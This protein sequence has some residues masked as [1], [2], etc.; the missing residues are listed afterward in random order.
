MNGVKD[1]T[2]TKNT[3]KTSFK[4]S[5]DFPSM[6]FGSPNSKTL[7]SLEGEDFESKTFEEK[8]QYYKELKLG[9]DITA[10]HQ[11]TN[12]LNNPGY[13]QL[14]TKKLAN[15]LLAENLRTKKLNTKPSAT[16][17]K[18]TQ[19][20]EQNDLKFQE[21]RAKLIDKKMADLAAGEKAKMATPTNNKALGMLAAFFKGLSKG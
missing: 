19:L 10:E 16:Q 21:Y 11:R 17:Q 7:N 8:Q 14:E 15:D 12:T 6:S 18:T 2:K 13:Q 20:K 3:L 4:S 1:L 5:K 9:N